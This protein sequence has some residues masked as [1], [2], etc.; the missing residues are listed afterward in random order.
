M[1]LGAN[2]RTSWAFVG[3]AGESG[4][5]SA[6]LGRLRG[7]LAPFESDAARILANDAG[8]NASTLDS[9]NDAAAGSRYTSENGRRCAVVAMYAPVELMFSSRPIPVVP[10]LA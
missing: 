3:A 6:Y 8:R 2:R 7:R 5:A 10:D 9:Q 1:R 4:Q